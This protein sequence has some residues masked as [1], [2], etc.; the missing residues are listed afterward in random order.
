MATPTDSL[1]TEGREKPTQGIFIGWL[2]LWLLVFAVFVALMSI[3]AGASHG[4]Q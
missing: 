1:V 2:A 3:V 4:W